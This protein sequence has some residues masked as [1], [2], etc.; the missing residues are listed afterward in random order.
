[1]CRDAYE[2]DSSYSSPP[3]SPILSSL[4]ML[5]Q[6]PENEDDSMAGWTGKRSVKPLSAHSIHRR[7]R[8]SSSS[9]WFAVDQS[10]RCS[11][12]C[13]CRFFLDILLRAASDPEV[14]LGEFAKG[15]RTGSSLATPASAVPTCSNRFFCDRTFELFLFPWLH[16]SGQRVTLWWNTRRRPWPVSEQRI[17]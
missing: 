13:P 2:R 15:V 3:T 17:V 9:S 1:M 10:T 6:E 12:G 14:A 11:P 7:F 4:S 8:E 16:A 5:R